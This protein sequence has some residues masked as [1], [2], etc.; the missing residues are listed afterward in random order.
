M[1]E[2]TNIAFAGLSVVCAALAIGTATRA[3]SQP[4][5]TRPLTIVAH[6]PEPTLT[7]IVPY[8][9]LSLATKEGKKVLMHRVGMAVTEVCPAVD[10]NGEALD[11]FACENF[12][13]DGARP[14]IHNAV[15]QALAGGI[16]T[17]AAIA[18]VSA[19]ASK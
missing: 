8:G 12:A 13:W 19:P 11:V 6:R 4:P 9:D 7:R 1:I 18:I 17:T 14:Q 15:Q 10:E 16:T 2:R 5:Y 3:L